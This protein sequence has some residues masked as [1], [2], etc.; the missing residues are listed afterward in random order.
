M[1]RFVLICALIALAGCSSRP[2]DKGGGDDNSVVIITNN[3]NNTSNNENNVVITECGPGR[4]L[5]NGACID[6]SL[7]NDNCGRCSSSCGTGT[8]CSNGS[9]ASVPT[10][11]RVEG[12]CPARYFCDEDTGLCEVGCNTNADCP[13]GAFCELESHACLCTDAGSVVCGSECVAETPLSC[14][15]SC[16]TCAPIANGDAVCNEG[17]CGQECDDGYMMCDG[18]C[19]SCP[20]GA[21]VLSVT[22]L[23]NECVANECEPGHEICDGTCAPCPATSGTE[24]LG[25]EGAQ[26]IITDCPVGTRLCN[27]T[28]ADCPDDPNGTL[29]CQGNACVLVCGSGFHSCGEFCAVDGDPDNCGPNCTFCSDDPNGSAVCAGGTCGLDCSTGYRECQGACSEC[30]D[31]P[32]VVSTMCAGAACVV[33]SCAAGYQPCTGGCCRPAPDGIAY[34][35]NISITDVSLAVD[36]RG[37]PH[38]AFGSASGNSIY[39]VWWDG[40]AWQSERVTSGWHVSIGLDLAENPHIAIWARNPDRL[41][42]ASRDPVNGWSTEEADNSFNDVGMTPDLVMVGNTPHIAYYDLEQDNL[43]YA[44]KNGNNWSDEVVASNGQIGFSPAMAITTTGDVHIVYRD[45]DNDWARH[46]YDVGFGWEYSVMDSTD[47]SGNY[48]ALTRDSNNGIHGAFV[49]DD[50]STG[51]QVYYTSWSNAGWSAPTFVVDG[52]KPSIV[53]DGQNN[54]IIVFWE[55]GSSIAMASE[56][57]G[58]TRVALD[59]A[60][61]GE[62]NDAVYDPVLDKVHVIFNEFTG[63]D[64]KYLTFDP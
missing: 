29:T 63:D 8:V 50:F 56:S 14:G 12:E 24:S 45:E 51:Q 23:G 7:D 37:Y 62:E 2:V 49:N 39:Y 44:V 40:S 38:I 18:T 59:T 55:I 1:L 53:T 6:T 10:D 35:Y 3:D 19:A 17:A 31:G 4:D 15:A 57:N 27:G 5:C 42:F 13:T 41:V 20:T 64:V 21:G 11:C 34:D 61:G 16:E 46:A 9:C 58:W 33:S 28:C 25:C 54:P 22:C 52:S 60:R 47:D 43:R 36:S 48:N 26:C 30:P 32:G